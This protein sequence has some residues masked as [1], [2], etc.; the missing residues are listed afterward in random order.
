MVIE[1]NIVTAIIGSA[2]VIIAALIAKNI[3][4]TSRKKIVCQK[5]CTEF[6]KNT[7]IQKVVEMIHKPQVESITYYD[8][9]VF[10]NFYEELYL[11]T[12]KVGNMVPEVVFC[13][14]AKH[15]IEASSNIAFQK[16]LGTN[17]CDP[18]SSNSSTE[19]IIFRKFIIEMKKIGNNPIKY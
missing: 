19:H 5:Y 17:F 9:L 4:T 3:S 16:A 8:A 10:V 13:M 15:A 18:Y 14:F 11:D 6:R 1:A 2:G 12:Y 7:S